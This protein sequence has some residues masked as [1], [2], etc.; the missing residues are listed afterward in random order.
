MHLKRPGESDKS[1]NLDSA[2]LEIENTI[3]HDRR[4]ALA[5]ARLAEP[6]VVAAVAH[7]SVLSGAFW[8]LSNDGLQFRT[9]MGQSASTFS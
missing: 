5:D 4:F 9:P 6:Q 3:K 1:G 8:V 2:T 7:L